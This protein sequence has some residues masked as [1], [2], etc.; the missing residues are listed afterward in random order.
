MQETSSELVAE[1]LEIGETY[2]SIHRGNKFKNPHTAHRSIYST[3]MA[4]CD[5]KD[6]FANYKV[7]SN[8]FLDK[9]EGRET[10]EGCGRSRKFF[11]YTCYLP[12][13]KI[14]DLIP[15]VQVIS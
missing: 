13:A 8:T 12:V 14:R 2:K 9:L 5:S 3:C 4:K 11:C 7:S 1:R 10:C 6:P 15:H